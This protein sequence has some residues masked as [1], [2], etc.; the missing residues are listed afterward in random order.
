MGNAGEGR[1]ADMKDLIVK[2][3]DRLDERQLGIVYHFI[4]GL[5]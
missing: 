3:L 4:L 1:K 5:M 2:M